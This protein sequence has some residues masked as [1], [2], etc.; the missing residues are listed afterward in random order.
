MRVH[1]VFKSGA[2]IDVDMDGYEQGVNNRTGEL[3]SLRWTTPEDFMKKLS[4][5]NMSEVAAIVRDR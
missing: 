5:I 2:S 4:F 3:Q 1:I